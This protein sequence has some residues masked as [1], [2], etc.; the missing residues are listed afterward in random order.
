[1]L[2]PLAADPA[3]LAA[4]LAPG[5]FPEAASTFQDLRACRQDHARTPSDDE[6]G[7]DPVCASFPRQGVAPLGDEAPSHASKNDVPSDS[8]NV[9]VPPSFI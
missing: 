2:L 3:H 7:G 6:Q 9:H 5:G 4:Q 8:D 1:V